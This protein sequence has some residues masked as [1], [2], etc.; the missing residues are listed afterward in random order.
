MRTRALLNKPVPTKPVL[1]NP[2]LIALI[3]VTVLALLSGCTPSKLHG[4]TPSRAPSPTP[5]FTSE[6]EALAAAEEVYTAYL[7]MSDLIAQEGGIEP[8]R[9]DPFTVGEFR[10]SSVAGYDDFAS[11]GYRS[12]GATKLRSFDLQ[13]YDPESAT[14]ALVAYACQDIS[15]VDVLDEQNNSVVKP[16]RLDRL[17]LEVVFALNGDGFRI[18]SQE[19]WST[20]SC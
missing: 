13:M 12:V 10:E 9:I 1:T 2:V 19:P 5:V 18:A 3:A 20:P 7:A 8:Q 4:K 14:G 17:R 11:K 16:N 15:G 6:E